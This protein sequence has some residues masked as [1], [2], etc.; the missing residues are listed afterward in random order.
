MKAFGVWLQHPADTVPREASGYGVVLASRA[1]PTNWIRFPAGNWQN[2]PE[3]TYSLL[4]EGRF[5]VS[6]WPS[7]LTWVREPFTG[8]G[9]A[10]TR[11]VVGAGRI[12][13]PPICRAGECTAWILHE[14]SNI[15]VPTPWF[16]PEMLRRAP[17]SFTS[18][19][20][21]LMPSGRIA[22]GVLD[23]SGTRFVGIAAPVQVTAG[24]DL[25]I[26]PHAPAAG[27]ASLVLE[28]NRPSLVK[29]RPDDDVSVALRF[30]NGRSELPAL[31]T[32]G[33]RKLTAVWTGIPVGDATL[34]VRS[35]TC[36]PLPTLGVPQGLFDGMRERVSYPRPDVV[37]LH[38][39]P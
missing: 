26:A 25:A 15:Q 17:L 18:S 38:A 24:R 3:G 37:T 20:G 29:A 16:A 2:P 13:I 33:A 34:E 12:R 30:G 11:S 23:A 39:L 28:L 9:W 21:V 1:D 19:E 5:E 36:P 6:P 31:L 7:S 22:V 4:V 10:I 27:S 32:R 35:S 14:D 8:K